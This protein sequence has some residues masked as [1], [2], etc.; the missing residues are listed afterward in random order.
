MA[1]LVRCRPWLGLV[2]NTAL[3]LFLCLVIAPAAQAVSETFYQCAQKYP[4][5]ETGRLKCYDRVVSGAGITPLSPGNAIQ[6]EET[7]ASQ[8]PA[9]SPAAGP[10]AV[11]APNLST[12]RSY[13]TRA[14]NLDDLSS[15]DPSKLGRLQPYKQNYLIVRRTNRPNVLPGSPLADHN[16]LTP[17]DLDAAEVKFRLSFKADIGSQRH[18]NFLGIKTF[19]LWGA[20]TQQSNWQ[21]F[22]TRNSSPFRETNYEPELIAT[23]GTGNASG[24]KLINLGWQH[25]SNG[26]PL[27]ESRSWN[28]LYL[29]G[30]WEWNNNTSFLARGWRRISEDPA[31]DENPD[32]ADYAGRADLVA[33]WEPMDKSQAV[34]ILLRNNLSGKNNRSFVQVDL[35]TPAKFGNAARMHIQ[36]TS[37]YGESMID[38]NYRQTTFGLG[39]S[40]REW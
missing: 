39:F 7:E 29:Q 33:R 31:K 34:A 25:Q 32:I 9:I 6:D 17:N 40:F 22:N 16:T 38:Y 24:L 11:A 26:R 20:Y 18:I 3:S 27:P 2:R 4:D 36:I 5:N 12:E 15:R 19:R 21:I 14:W 28:R 13:F 8:T 1:E 30:G 10:G 35:A 23:L 37:G